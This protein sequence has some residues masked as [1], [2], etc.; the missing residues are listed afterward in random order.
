M[1]K[2]NLSQATKRTI[3]NEIKS[4]I[5]TALK[6]NVERGTVV[7]SRGDCLSFRVET[8]GTMKFIHIGG[9]IAQGAKDAAAAAMYSLNYTRS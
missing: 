3:R 8:I 6:I 1:S 5:E 4:E 7:T 9:E 2:R